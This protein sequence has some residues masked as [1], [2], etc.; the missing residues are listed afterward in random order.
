MNRWMRVVLIVALALSYVAGLV[1]AIRVDRAAR[2][3]SG[4]VEPQIP[5]NGCSGCD[6][7]W[8]EVLCWLSGC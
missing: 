4:G 2:A 5:W 8:G 3:P 6:A 1:T 7:R